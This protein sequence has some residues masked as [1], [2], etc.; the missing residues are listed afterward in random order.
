MQPEPADEEVS[1]LPEPT[2]PPTLLLPESVSFAQLERDAGGGQSRDAADIA[3]G[4]ASCAAVG[5]AGEHDAE[6]H[7]ADD[8]ADAVF[9]CR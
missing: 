4:L 6:V 9:F 1:S 2:M 5:F 7:L 8:A 3:A